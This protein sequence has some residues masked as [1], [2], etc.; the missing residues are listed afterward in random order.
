MPSSTTVRRLTAPVRPGAAAHGAFRRGL[1]A[2]VGAVLGLALLAG[3]VAALVGAGRTASADPTRQL[4]D[5]IRAQEAA[6]NAK[7][8]KALTT[9]ARDLA[10][11]LMPVL[12]QMETAM[13]HEGRAPRAAG[14]A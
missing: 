8:V 12:G 11:R 4:A 2:G 14:A 7:Q 1:F 3:L 5:C 9:Q 10:T 13:P 6:R